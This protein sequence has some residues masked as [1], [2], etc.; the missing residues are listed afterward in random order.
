MSIIE[1][2][3]LVLRPT[4][5]SDAQ[6]IQGYFNNWEII[7]WMRPPVPWPY[8]KDGAAEYL[9]GLQK[10]PSWKSFSIMPHNET[11]VIGTIRYECHNDGAII[12]AERGF[13]LSQEYWGKGLMSEAADALNNHIFSTTDANEIRAFNAVGN[14]ASHKIKKKQ[15]FIFQGI[16]TSDKPYHIGEAQEE[17]WIL[18]KDVWLSNT[19]D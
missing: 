13:V 14:V 1:T 5:L 3:R 19:R 7:K 17:R 10:K 2:G 6:D 11:K 18:P 8:P 16:F 15:G 4:E 12:Y 9:R